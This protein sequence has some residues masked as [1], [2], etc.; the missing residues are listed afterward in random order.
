MS[1]IGSSGIPDG[2]TYA[3][4]TVGAIVLYGIFVTPLFILWCISLCIARRKGDPARAGIAWI[5]AVYP[6]WILY[7][8]LH[9]IGYALR[10]WT[11]LVE[12]DNDV[13]SSRS[14]FTTIS[15]AVSQASD[16][17]YDIA[18]LFMYLANILLLIAFFELSN[19][20]LLCLNG[21]TPPPLQKRLRYA[22]LSF[23]LLVF[24]LAIAYLGTGEQFYSTYYDYLALPGVDSAIE[25]KLAN[26]ANTSNRL[27][28]AVDI[29]LWIASLPAIGYASLV[30]HQTKNHPPLHDPA[31][32]LLASTALASLRL[33]CLM[34]ITARYFLDPSQAFIPPYVTLTVGPLFDA[35]CMFVVL[36]LLFTLAARKQKGLWSVPPPQWAA[37][38]WVPSMGVAA[39]APAGQPGMV[40]QGPGAYQ[41]QQPQPQPQPY[42]YYPPPQQ[43][44]G[45]PQP[46]Q[47]AGYPHEVP[48]NLQ[49]PRELEQQQ[50]VSGLKAPAA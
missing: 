13:F 16:R 45:Y 28:A 9:T 12:Y 2:N 7:L 47:G 26:E 38:A 39:P 20:F 1:D 10:L 18:R 6:L 48:P 42:Y 50:G 33:L 23:A 43:M 22:I 41:S 25:V 32:L 30:V 11:Y 49:T 44:G 27:G 21:G 46:Q 34:I 29:L 3:H 17:F 14:D 24:A 35:V 37:P 5:K 15:R 40:W 4:Y 8:V 31:I 36:V 19:G